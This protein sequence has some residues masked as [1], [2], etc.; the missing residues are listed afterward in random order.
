M[1]I[2]LLNKTK[3]EIVNKYLKYPLAVAEKDYFLAI[4]S[5]IIYK[6]SGIFMI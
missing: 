2:E 6:D 5:K 1:I 3:L 4:I